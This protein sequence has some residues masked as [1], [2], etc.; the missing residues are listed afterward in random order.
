MANSVDQDHIG[1]VCSGSTLSASIIEF[2]S[3]VRKLFCSKRLQQTP[4]F[5]CIFFGVLRVIM[6]VI[7]TRKYYNQTLKTKPRHSE[8]E[9]QDIIQPQG[10]SQQEEN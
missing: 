7:M 5:R 6:Y 3:N 8:E 4:F 9:T 1:A 10:Q 2:V